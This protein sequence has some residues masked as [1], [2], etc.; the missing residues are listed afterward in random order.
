MRIAPFR[1]HRVLLLAAACLI[2]WPLRGADSPPAADKARYLIIHAD[3]AGLCHSANRATAEALEKGIVTSC[4]IMM[5]CPWLIEFAE[6]AK[7]HPQFDY[8]VHLTLNAEWKHYRWGPVAGKDRVPSLVD[9]HGY[10]WSN[11]EQVAKHAKP[12]EVAIELR[13]QIARAKQLGIPLSHLDTHMGA[14]VSRPDLAEIYV[15]LGIEH[16][17]PVL[18]F[19]DADEKTLAAYPAL[20]DVGPPLVARLNEQRLPLLD[21]LA[22][23]YGGDS[24]EQR[25]ENYV[26]AV[27]SLPPGVTQLI[28]HCGVDDDELRAVTNS[29][30]RRDSDRRIFTD[31]EIARRIRDEGIRLITWKQFRELR[32]KP[33]TSSGQK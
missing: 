11:V 31:P 33:P 15:A 29:A 8:G 25:R 26:K 2:A 27:Q 10:L 28:I 4:S 21:G 6:Y 7:A 12:E 5:P 23:F 17:L 13:A 32:A 22:Q 3:D 1:R 24:H 14:L 19:R 9:E 20:R 18:F 30:E 16:D